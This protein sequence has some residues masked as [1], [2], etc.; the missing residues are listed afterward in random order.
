MLPTLMYQDVEKQC[1]NS[2]YVFV[3][4]L[5]QTEAELAG[6]R[7]DDRQPPTQS[8]SLCAPGN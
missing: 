4:R 8:L 7:S 5:R 1:E 3:D 2:V 6:R